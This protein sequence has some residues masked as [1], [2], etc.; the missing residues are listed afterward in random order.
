MILNDQ[1]TRRNCK[2]LIAGILMFLAVPGRAQLTDDVFKLKDCVQYTLQHHPN[3]TI[4]NN[5]VG[6]AQ[7]KVRENRAAFLPSVSGQVNLDYN[8]KLQTSIIP[9]GAFGSTETQLQI[10]NK[11]STGAYI[12]ADQTIFDRSSRMAIRSAKVEKEISDLNVLKENENLIYNTAVA[13]YE[14]LT[15]IEKGKLL[16]KNELQYRQLLD[17]L[18]L[19]FDQG[20]VK[21]SEYDRT[22]VSLNNIQAE[23][24]LNE[25]NYALSLNKLK[26]A[27]GMDLQTSIN[28]KDSISFSSE[29]V[30]PVI[31]ELTTS[32]LLSHR[33]DQKNV[34]LKEVDLLKKK[35]A[36]LPVLSAYAKYGA[37]AY[38]ANVE[39]SFDRW[40]DYSVIGLK[41][42][43]P[44]FSGFKK[45]SQFNQSKINAENE[46]LTLKLNDNQHNLD[47]QNSGSR[48]F[49][50]YTSLIKNKENLDLAKEV[51]DATAVEYR[52]GSATMA[53][54]LDDDYAYKEAQSN[55]INSLIDYLNSQLAYEKAKGTLTVYIDSLD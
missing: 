41:L 7:E 33:I 52:E 37:N 16:E 20:V 54:F 24:A 38:S 31:G 10:G 13:Y 19:R 22:R 42:S 32:E 55:Y 23:M 21:K 48:L 11:F 4:N 18:K 50:S 30:K 2:W 27:M 36:Y 45:N 44:V 49:S 1:K 47:Y 3:S 9:A 6:V 51:L 29:I 14:V 8:L 40:F 39:N 17:I 28:L 34:L 53:T 15:N 5:K 26:N 35:T 12:Q 25:N 43:V 46:R